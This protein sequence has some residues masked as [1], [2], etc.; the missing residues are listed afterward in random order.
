[1]ALQGHGQVKLGLGEELAA[2]TSS[3]APMAVLE[4]FTSAACVTG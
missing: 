3:I 2:M 1:M 4:I